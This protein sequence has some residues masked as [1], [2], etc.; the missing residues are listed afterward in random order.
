MGAS[1]RGLFS[2]SL[3]GPARALR[4]PS[5]GSQSRSRQLAAELLE[6]R[7]AL[8]ATPTA[9]VAGPVL[10]GLIGQDIPLTVSFDNT[11]TDIGYS[12][13]VDIV[14]PATGDAPPTPNDGISFMPGSASY[15]GLSLVT[16]VLTFDAA[17]NAT[18][19]FAKKP[20]G[21][22][23]IVTGKAGDQL[24]V[25][26]LPFGSYVPDQPAAVINFTGSV[27]PLAQ[28]NQPLFVTATGGFQYQVDGSGNP[29]IN[30]ADF[31][32]K[33][34]DP[35]Q[36]QLF[37]IKKTSTAPEGE[38]ATGPNFTH[39]Y[40]VSI[41]VAPGQTVTDMLLSDVLPNNLQFVSVTTVSGNGT[42]TITPVSTP[43]T[44]TPGGT[45]S[46][47]LD[48]VV[49]TGKA[50]DAVMTFTYFVPEKDA[51]NADVIPLGT[52]GTAVAVNTSSA[53]G[54][55]TSANPNFPDEQTVTSS[56]TDPDSKHTLTAKT[57]AL[58]KTVADLTHPGSPRAGD[59]LEYTLNFQVSDY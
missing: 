8:A 49:G 43:T 40:T 4:R 51:S 5:R 50:S 21:T 25:V 56:P 42:T 59:T 26:Q 24:V 45:L 7:Y 29:T 16:T 38:T 52:G 6:R 27:S 19:P 33:S 58:Q 30:V 28:P 2:R 12:P 17:G 3:G 13:F 48:Q 14:M 10:S 32:S 18:H 35:V 9:T 15:N 44:S 36:P 23:V 54:K 11:G 46:R 20:D 37:R 1:S 34:T 39:S 47:R 53:E 57:T 31:G 41:A 55:W 22:P